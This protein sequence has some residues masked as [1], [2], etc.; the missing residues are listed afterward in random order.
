MPPFPIILFSAVVA[1]SQHVAAFRFSYHVPVRFGCWSCQHRNHRRGICSLSKGVVV[2][3]FC[4]KPR[5]N[6]AGI[7]ACY[8]QWLPNQSYVHAEWR[9]PTWAAIRTA[10]PVRAATRASECDCPQ[11]PSAILCVSPRL[12][13]QRWHLCWYHYRRQ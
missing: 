11:P 2:G 12:H 6:F 3:T 4:Q 1:F 8:W 10:W 9:I 5:R 7:S 13:P